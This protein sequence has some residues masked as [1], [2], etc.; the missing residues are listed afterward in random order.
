[1]LE[2]YPYGHSKAQAEALVQ[3]SGRRSLIVRPT[4]VAGPAAPAFAGLVKL[5]RMPVCPLFAG[6]KARLQPIHVADLAEWMTDLGLRADWPSSIVE[7]GGPE[8]ITAKDLLLRLRKERLGRS[9]RGLSFPLRPLRFA[10][11]LVEGPL[12]PVL[13]LTS[14]QLASFAEDGTAEASDDWQRRRATM[15]SLEEMV[16]DDG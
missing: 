2:H 14:G 8:V 11:R 7:M 5:A 6:G 1:D 16:A 4:L 9:P 13:P 15:K 12:W 3:A 10:L